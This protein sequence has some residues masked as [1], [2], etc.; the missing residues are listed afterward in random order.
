[1]SLLG[2]KILVTGASSGIGK[3]TAVYLSQLGASLIITARKEEPL[4]ETLESLD[5][6]GHST[7][8]FELKEIEEIESFIDELVMNSGKLD[9]LVHC[10]GIGEMRPL[11]LAKYESIHETML[12]NFYAF[13]ELCRVI[14]KKKNYNERA[15]LVAISSVA[16]QRGQKSKLAYCASKSALDSAV[17]VMAKELANKKIRVNTVVPGFLRT[18]MYDAYLETAGDAEFEK[19]VLAYQYLGLGQAEDA[20]SA[21]AY[22]LSEASKFITGTGLVVDGGYLS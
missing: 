7:M 18:D 13:I 3:A 16:G 22:L 5:G 1:M 17:K 12:V 19:N 9:G 11:Q 21:I 6:D 14:S 4:K 15:S 10:A 8:I 2:K 20:A